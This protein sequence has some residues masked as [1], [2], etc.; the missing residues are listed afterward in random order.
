MI[1]H[2]VVS[3]PK[4]LTMTDGMCGS[5]L[6]MAANG[7]NVE[8]LQY[9]VDQGMDI[10]SRIIGGKNDLHTAAVGGHLTMIKHLVDNHP[11]LLTMTDGI[12]SSVLDDT[13]EFEREVAHYLFIRLFLLLRDVY[14]QA[15]QK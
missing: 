1:K 2:L 7:G 10:Q 6:H 3:Y 11:Q 9:L 15:L 8:A 5:A 4:L 12:H 14:G 13:P